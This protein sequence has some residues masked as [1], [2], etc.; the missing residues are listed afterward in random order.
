MSCCGHR[1]S[2][3]GRTL[4]IAA[5][6]VAM[7]SLL[8]AFPANANCGRPAYQECFHLQSDVEG[9][10]RAGDGRYLGRFFGN[11][12]LQCTTEADIEAAKALIQD[13]ASRGR[14]TSNIQ[15]TDAQDLLERITRQRLPPPQAETDAVAPPSPVESASKPAPATD[16][17][18]IQPTEPASEAASAAVPVSDH[19]PAPNEVQQAPE[20][21]FVVSTQGIQQPQPQPQQATSTRRPESTITPPSN[22]KSEATFPWI[23]V[24]VVI[25]AVIVL[26]GIVA[27]WQEKIVVFRNYNDL[28]MM[29]FMVAAPISIAFIG[30]ATSGK[31]FQT[32]FLSFILAGI[33]LAVFLGWASVRT[34]NDQ[35]PRSIWTFILA[36]ITKISLGVLF[37]DAL[38]SAISPGGK[39]QVARARARGSALVRL[40][41]LTPL[42]MRLVRSH[43]GIWS[44]QS[45]LN[46]RQRRR[47]VM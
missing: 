33:V 36:L 21:P 11:N 2:L 30:L 9:M 6:A 35:D 8:A 25:W 15:V 12:D 29:F 37:V 28:A 39:T 16:L 20:A 13:C 24:G 27:G 23:W 47:V 10:A 40:A 14:W 5:K 34:W 31:D 1:D 18:N 43:E 7:L 22:K 38:W 46:T 3:S 19:V 26:I 41:V 4:L 32:A 45:M 44:P 17:A 42:V